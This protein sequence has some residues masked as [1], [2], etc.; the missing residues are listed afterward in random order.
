MDSAASRRHFLKA[1]FRQTVRGTTEAARSYGELKR[2]LIFATT[3][4]P[5][6][7]LELPAPARTL[8]AGATRGGSAREQLPE[9]ARELGL[10]GCDD[11]L[12]ALARP[13]ARLVHSGQAER[14]RLARS[15]FGGPPS[16]PE[17]TPWPSWNDAPLGFLA[18]LDLA[19]AELAPALGASGLPREGRL[20]IFYA[21]D[22][23]PSGMRAG[24]EGAVRLLLADADAAPLDPAACE[25]PIAAASYAI[26]PSPELMLPRQWAAPVQALGLDDAE[27][28]AWG[29]LR[30]RLAALQGTSGEAAAIDLLA[31]HRVLGWPDERT[32][33]MPLA[34][35]LLARGVQLDRITA[36]GFH[37]QAAAASE[38]AGDWRLLLQLSNDDELGWQWAGR[39]RSRLY[40]WIHAERLA[41]GDLSAVRAFPR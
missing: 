24:D 14:K 31:L 34:C 4:E 39:P 9:L 25:G 37:P 2:T 22:A 8:R 18:Q 5:P 12:R 36:P 15:R 11:A 17:G 21:T 16:L 13:S 27:L 41:A 10:E 6:P 30:D 19:E 1:A 29:A 28:A 40:V 35:A 7:G 26:A 33:E 20:L 3:E 32:G 23:Q 38:E